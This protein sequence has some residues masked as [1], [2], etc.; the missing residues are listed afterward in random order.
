MC[1][2]IMP[3]VF[4]SSR[5]PVKDRYMAPGMESFSLLIP[6]DLLRVFVCAVVASSPCTSSSSTSF[7]G[8]G[9]ATVLNP[10]DNNFESAAVLTK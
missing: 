3:F 6:R 8:S 7:R 5:R 9:T 4:I 10:I 2:R 1:K